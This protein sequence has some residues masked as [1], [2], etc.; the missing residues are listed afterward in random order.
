MGQS[1][2]RT[3][4]WGLALCIT[5]DTLWGIGHLF[6]LVFQYILSFCFPLNGC[7]G[8]QF[9]SWSIVGILGLYHEGCISLTLA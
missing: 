6:I 5:V 7:C 3:G 4:P 8:W 9:S 2:Y 1:E